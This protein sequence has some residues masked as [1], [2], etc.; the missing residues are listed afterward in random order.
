M[1]LAHVRRH[2]AGLP[3]VTLSEREADELAE[4]AGAGLRPVV[5]NS[6]AQYFPDVDYLLR[7]LEGAAAALRPGG[8]IFVGDV[9]SL[10]LA[11]AFHA[12]VELARAPEGLPTGQLQERVR[13]GMAEEQELLLDPALFEAL[14]ARIPRLGRVEVQVKRGEYDNEVSRFRYDVVLH[15]D[16]DPA[17]AADPVV[18][19][20]S[21]E[22]V[23]GLRALAAGPAGAARPWRARRA[24]PRA[25]PRVRAGIGRR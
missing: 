3:Q 9:R 11:G 22:D 23:D 25:R 15:L 12:S 2:A 21:G 24:G 14:R 10:P 7:V 8:R 17:D 5:V 13:R 1:A 4:F 19:D 6:V 18:R 16:A 20:W